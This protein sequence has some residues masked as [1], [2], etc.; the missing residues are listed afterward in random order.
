MNPEIEAEALNT[1]Q[2]LIRTIYGPKESSEDTSETLSGLAKEICDECL[3][4]M[5][6]PEKSQAIPAS[7][8]MASLIGT[9]GKQYNMKSVYIY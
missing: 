1:T 5:K 7:K 2:I 6:E 3:E 9:T 4:L 8:V